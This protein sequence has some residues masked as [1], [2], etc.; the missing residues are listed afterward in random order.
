MAKRASSGHKLG[1]FVG[2]WFEQYF[3][4]PLLR[5]VADE[6][7]LYLD[8]RFV[9]RPL[10]GGEKVISDLAEHMNRLSSTLSKSNDS[11]PRISYIDGVESS[12]RSR[13]LSF[14]TAGRSARASIAGSL[15]RVAGAQ[16]LSDRFE[17]LLINGKNET[18]KRSY[19]AA[20][21]WI[22]FALDHSGFPPR[23]GAWGDVLLQE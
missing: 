2:D 17:Q 3:S 20:H 11:G 21:S 12:L 14:R 15:S 19:K 9:S 1:Q 16:W 7:E 10:R 8:N 23:V 4:L 18:S 5:Q 22:A 6:L 13:S